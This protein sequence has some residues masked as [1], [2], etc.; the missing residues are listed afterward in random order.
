MIVKFR[1]SLQLAA[2]FVVFGS[3]PAFAGSL[4]LKSECHCEACQ[5]MR[6][7]RGLL[8]KWAPAPPAVNVVDSIPARFTTVRADR[9]TT[10]ASTNP[11]PAPPT[12]DVNTRLTD[13]EA[14]LTRL[15]QKIDGILTA[16][17]K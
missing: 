12:G 9:P 5:Q 10:P 4:L 2:L 13:V 1:N 11:P 3:V 16:L 17:E 6:A 8:E 15:E 7:K 14:R